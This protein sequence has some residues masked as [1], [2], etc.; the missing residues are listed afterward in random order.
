MN[1]VKI[2]A[3][4]IILGTVG[5]SYGADRDLG[6]LLSYKLDASGK[7]AFGVSYTYGKDP[8]GTNYMLTFTPKVSPS[9]GAK[10]LRWNYYLRT[11][12]SFSLPWS[13]DHKIQ[14]AVMQVLVKDSKPELKETVNRMLVGQKKVADKNE[15]Y[16]ILA[17]DNNIPL[18]NVPLSD[19]CEKHPDHFH[20]MTYEKRCD[21][22]LP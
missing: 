9:E 21:E 19:L 15:L 22:I 11:T 1:H 6:T 3:L 18:Y 14:V 12:D 5:V 20:D 2:W 4:A 13:D 17:D 10:R 16:F 7:P 8:D